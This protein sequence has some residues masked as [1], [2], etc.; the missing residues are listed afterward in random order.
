MAATA[1]SMA[2]M[3]SG[4]A[5]PFAISPGS[6][7]VQHPIS[8]P[9]VSSVMKFLPKSSRLVSKSLSRPSQK[10]HIRGTRSTVQ[11]LEEESGSAAGA[12]GDS[13]VSEVALLDEEPE[14]PGVS[15]ADPTP[16]KATPLQKGG[17]LSGSEALGKDPSGATLGKRSGTSLTGSFEDPRWLKGTWDLSKFTV[18]GKV[19]WDSVIDAEVVRRKWLEDNPEA[20]SDAEP[21][22]FESGIIPWWAWVRRFHLP[23]AELLNGRAAMVGYV[24]AY[25]V[26]S[27]TGAGL[28]DQQ[29]SFLGKLLLF[30]TV[31]GVL[32]IRKNEDLVTL[33]TLA[34]ESTFYDKQWQATWKEDTTKEEKHSD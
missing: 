16:R 12:S 5:S 21:I 8:T 10:R 2:A 32:L 13:V 25:L 30:V 23:E 34:K 15:S 19:N 7:S 14:T 6:K 28:V 3:V 9:R 22:V 27:A 1:P 20:S 26:D 4:M 11:V 24:A 33:K 31:L 29:S 18:D 17:T